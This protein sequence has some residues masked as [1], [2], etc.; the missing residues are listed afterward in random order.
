MS[1]HLLEAIQ[2]LRGLSSDLKKE[3][4]VEQLRTHTA[5]NEEQVSSFASK[6]ANQTDEAATLAA[7]V[8]SETLG[9]SKSASFGRAVTSNTSSRG[10][11]GAEFEKRFT[12]HDSEF[13]SL[14][15]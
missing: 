1:Q 12:D 6:F 5:M 15:F 4:A 10:D 9:K 14:D 2:L 8:I 11:S 7:E 3:A 13:M